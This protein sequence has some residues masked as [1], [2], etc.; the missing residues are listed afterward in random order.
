M[1][2]PTVDKFLGEIAQILRDKN[3]AKLQQYLVYEPPFV[4]LYQQ[5]I[6]EIRQV[7]GPGSHD[8]LEKKCTS[9]IP[10][11]DDGVDG[12]SR[13]SFITFMVKYFV[14]LRDLDVT[15]LVETHDQLKALLK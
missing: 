1:G 9:F 8:V 14:F 3:G 12:G 2:P 11:Y 15:N 6:S 13:T 5:M 7:Y 10:E 4:P